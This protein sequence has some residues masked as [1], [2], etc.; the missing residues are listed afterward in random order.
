MNV[1][2]YKVIE[3]G[4]EYTIKEYPRGNNW[5]FL[6]GKHHRINGPAVELDDGTKYWFLDN[7]QYTKKT[8]YKELLK[9][10]LI[11]KKDAFIELI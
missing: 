1:K 8:Y 6:N 10:K 4:I 11:S 9:R 5:W 3:N 2:D 7:R